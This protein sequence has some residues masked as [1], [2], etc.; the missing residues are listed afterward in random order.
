MKHP[1]LFSGLLLAAVACDEK[2]ATPTDP[3]AGRSRHTIVYSGNMWG[4]LLE[5]G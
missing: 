1:A 5:C 4:D 3:L 2:A